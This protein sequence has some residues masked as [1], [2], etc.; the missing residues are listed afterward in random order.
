MCPPVPV[1]VIDTWTVAFRAYPTKITP[2]FQG[3]KPAK[4]ARQRREIS[5]DL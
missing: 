1:Q 2:C 4:T 3:A 5:K